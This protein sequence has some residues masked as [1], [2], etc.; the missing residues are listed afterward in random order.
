MAFALAAP[1]FYEIVEHLGATTSAGVARWAF[2]LMALAALHVAYAVYVWQVPDWGSVFV[3]ALLE[4]GQAMVLAFALGLLL[5]SK[6]EHALA[7]WFDLA[8]A[9]RSDLARLWCFFALALSSAIAFLSG[10]YGL[11]WRRRLAD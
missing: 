8:D 10:R 4:L 1:S 11:A 6:T 9:A 7:Q 3:V 5:A 2:A